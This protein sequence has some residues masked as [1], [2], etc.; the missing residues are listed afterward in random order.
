MSLGRISASRRFVPPRFLMSTFVVAR[1][2]AASTPAN[3]SPP[4]TVET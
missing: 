1:S 3:G 4:P 2:T